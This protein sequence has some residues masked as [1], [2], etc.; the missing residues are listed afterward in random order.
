MHVLQCVAVYCS[1]LQCVL[2]IWNVNIVYCSVMQRVTVCVA[3]CCSVLQFILAI[4]TIFETE[5]TES[6]QSKSRT[7]VQET[8]ARMCVDVCCRIL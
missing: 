1:V 7:E 2:A 8:S 6:T 5:A 4:W 3:V